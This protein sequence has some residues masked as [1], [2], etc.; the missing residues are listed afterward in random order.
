MDF[1]YDERTQALQAE[2]LD[3]MQAHVYPAEPAFADVGEDG[4]PRAEFRRPAVLGE[5]K[6]EAR[7]RGLWNLFLPDD[8]D[9][10]GLTLLQY[11]PLAETS[12]RSPLVAPEAM[13]CAAPD[14]G[15]MELLHLFGTPEQRQRW[16]R[17]MLD[18]ELRSAYCMTEPMVASSDA[19]NLRTRIRRDGDEYVVDGRKWWST[20]VLAEECGLLVVVG[21]TDPAAGPR[22]RESVVLVPRDAP[23][24]TVMRPL[25]VF[26]YLD[27]AHGGHG[28]VLFEG[29][30]VPR[31]N[32]LGEEGRGYALAQARLGPGRVHHCMRLVGIA[33]RAFDLMCHRGYHRTTFGRL[34]A[35][36]D[37]FQDWVAEARLRID[38]TRLLVLRAA[39]LIDRYGAR[40]ARTE[41]SAIKAAAPAMAEWVVDRAIQ[42]YGGAGLAQDLPLA[43]LYAHARGLRLADGPDE[44]HRMVVARRELARYA[45][46]AAGPTRGGALDT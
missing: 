39:W 31:E 6:A 7:R 5:L 36:R 13:N 16:L 9:G 14:T 3:F 32:L 35:D 20:G 38:A 40:E 37:T 12:G 27:S 46:G 41:I 23:G 19:A 8:R 18:G 43:M 42:A 24:V 33:E 4:R 17:P 11:A 30:R 15:N 10:A 21:V 26:G 22:D 1:A 29:V 45:P 25:S 44:V 28:E 34:L 2:L